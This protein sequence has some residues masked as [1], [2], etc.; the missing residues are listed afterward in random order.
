MEAMSVPLLSLLRV[1]IP[2]P[3]STLNFAQLEKLFGG[4][5]N[6]AP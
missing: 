3:A 4:D 2:Y 1:L 6:A 5:L